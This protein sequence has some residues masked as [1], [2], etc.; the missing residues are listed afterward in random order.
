MSGIL[1]QR[2]VRKI[3]EQCKVSYAPE[4]Q[5]QRL[6]E[7]LGISLPELFRGAGC[8]MCLGLGYKGRTGIFELLVMS[9]Q[10]RELLMQRAI[11]DKLYD[12]ACV[13]GM[14]PMLLDGIEKVKNGLVTL[15]EIIKAVS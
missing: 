12:Q 15:Q 6:L 2:L 10:V 8:K 1:A 3:C 4:A 14:Q 7:K 11:R 5:E 9:N 13:D